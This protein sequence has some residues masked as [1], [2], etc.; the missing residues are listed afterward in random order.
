MGCRLRSAGTWIP[1]RW[2]I[3]VA[4]EWNVRTA[5]YKVPSPGDG[6]SVATLAAK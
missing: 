6:V 3:C 4:C 1:L 5:I 2:P